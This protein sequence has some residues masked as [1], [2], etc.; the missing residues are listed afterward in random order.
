MP[1]GEAGIGPCRREGGSFASP[2]TAAEAHVSLA[3]EMMKQTWTA[4]VLRCAVVA[5]ALF[6]WLSP[7]PASAQAVSGTIFGTVYDSSGAALPGATVTLTNAATG[8][9]P[10]L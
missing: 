1:L 2:T 3:E 8:L 9:T 5:L 4:G 6:P 10:S 7:R